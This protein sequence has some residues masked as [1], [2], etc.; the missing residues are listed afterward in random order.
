M[1]RRRFGVATIKYL[2]G[3]LEYVN[4]NVAL[5][6]VEG[7]DHLIIKSN[8][9]IIRLEYRGNNVNYIHCEK[10]LTKSKNVAIHFKAAGK[11]RTFFLDNI[12]AI[13]FLKRTL[14]KDN[15]V[16][17]V[18]GD[19]SNCSASNLRLIKINSVTTKPK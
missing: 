17:H 12:I 4:P 8:G 14:S 16:I 5:L 9:E 3:D 2:T 1:K 15:R 19:K 18:D 13:L 7:G 10:H 11:I 6:K